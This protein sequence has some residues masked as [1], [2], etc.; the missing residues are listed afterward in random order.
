MSSQNQF[1][2]TKATLGNGMT[3]SRWKMPHRWQGTVYHGD[4]VPLEI[5]RC[6]PGDTFT[7]RV[8]NLTRT[9]TA[10]I[11]PIMDNIDEHFAAFFV[12]DRLI[13]DKTKQFY[14]ENTEGYGIQSE[15]LAPRATP[16]VATV[17]SA[18]ATYPRSFGTYLGI[19]SQKTDDTVLT[20]RIANN[21]IRAFLSC[22]NTWFRNQNFMAP[23]LWSK[24]ESGDLSAT[25]FA[26]NSGN[27]VSFIT[28]VPKVCKKNDVFTTCL[29]WSQKL[30]STVSLPLGTTAPVFVTNPDSE[31]LIPHDNYFLLG[32]ADTAAYFSPQ[33]LADKIDTDGTA[34]GD[35]IKAD[36]KVDLSRATAASISQLRMAVA[37]QRYYESLARCGSFY[38]Q[39]IKEFFDVDTGDTTAQIPEFLGG[40]KRRLNVASIYS[41]A[42]YEAGTSTKLAAPGAVCVTEGDDILFRK[43]FKEPG[44]VVIVYYTKHDRSYG[45]GIDPI[46]T[47]NKVLQEYNPKFAHI[48]ET[49][50]EKTRL[51]F[52]G[53]SDDNDSYLGFQ[54][55]WNEYRYISD[56][57]IG[58][59]NV[60]NDSA[61]TFINLADKYASAPVLNADFLTENR[62]SIARCLAGGSGSP[63]YFLDVFIDADV[64]RPMPVH[65]VP[66]LMDHF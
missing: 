3:R 43:S 46:W 65:S 14:G 36:L 42:G 19:V 27:Y 9:A 55:A 23:Y 31:T 32:N 28:D 53:T 16:Y 7:Y 50:V 37:L 20:P 48:S 13:W 12:P 52:T 21:P 17:K 1:T 62:D 34:S 2:Y 18:Y 30:A 54:E 4:L 8:K 47:K 49:P 38:Q 41:T 66:G 11:Y 5:T 6:M 64:I 29:P 51:Y 45:Q 40:I 60:A 24:S 35:P 63:D 44:Y 59:L 25:Y 58:G 22:Y 56:K 10:P 15:V 33:L 39:Y 26:T 61:Y 57:V